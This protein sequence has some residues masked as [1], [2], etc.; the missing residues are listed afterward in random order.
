ML[1]CSEYREPQGRVQGKIVGQ[2][3]IEHKGEGSSDVERDGEE[4]RER[5]T[6]ERRG[7]SIARESEAR[8]PSLLLLVTC[9]EAWAPERRVRG[10]VI[11]SNG[12]HHQWKMIKIMYRWCLVRK[13]TL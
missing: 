12:I 6:S 1:D 9:N 4:E 5:D 13:Q 8:P 10:M 3:S 2:E 11:K 7:C